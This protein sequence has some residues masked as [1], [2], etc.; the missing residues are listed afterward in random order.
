MRSTDRGGARCNPP[1]FRAGDNAVLSFGEEREGSDRG[2]A[3]ASWGFV[4]GG[5]AVEGG[6]VFGSNSSNNSSR[7]KAAMLEA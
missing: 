5:Y 3:C 7:G 2:A 6:F 1:H 4:A